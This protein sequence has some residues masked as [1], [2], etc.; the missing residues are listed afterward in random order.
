MLSVSF[1]R[2]VSIY[3]LRLI[4]QRFG[5]KYY[6]QPSAISLLHLD[7]VNYISSYLLQ[8]PAFGFH[9]VNAFR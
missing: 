8:S 7:L 5:G 3:Y 9:S 6:M 2:R 1:Y 4:T